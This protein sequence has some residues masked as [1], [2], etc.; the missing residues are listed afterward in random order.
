MSFSDGEIVEQYKIK[1]IDKFEFWNLH[2]MSKQEFMRLIQ[3][4]IKPLNHQLQENFDKMLYAEEFES[5]FD[6]SDWGIIIP[7]NRH[8][9]M[10]IDDE[11]HQFI[12]N[13]FYKNEIPNLFTVTWSGI[14]INDETK[15]INI[16]D[17]HHS[18]EKIIS[19]KFVE[20][21]KCICPALS[22][23]TLYKDSVIN[24]NEENY[25]KYLVIHQMNK[26]RKYNE[27]RNIITWQSECADLVSFYETLL[28]RYKKDGGNHKI[29]LRI[30]VLLE[31]YYRDNINDIDSMLNKLFDYRNEF[32]HG[33]I[34]R[35]LCKEVKKTPKEEK[36]AK[37][38]MF[39]T[40]FL[41][42]NLIVA[43]QV[44]ISFLYLSLK[45]KLDKDNVPKQIDDSI[46]DINKRK[47]IQ[48]H[49]KYI[50]KLLPYNYIK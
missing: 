4:R 36:Y 18:H 40:K 14:S 23:Y 46:L 27:G 45:L 32:I 42:N 10:F 25:R 11:E 5:V 6:R 30:E 19:N 41:Q 43:K 49:V 1:T 3:S 2:Q 37:I 12:I 47:E 39:D 38:P 28:S 22:E 29:K 35:R 15:L 44:F 33:D 24:W 50:L 34:F 9:K 31:A 17:Y 7:E 48:K 16:T 20:F 26:L 8:N 13:L 21:Y